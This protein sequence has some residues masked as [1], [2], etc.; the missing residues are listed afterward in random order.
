MAEVPER[1]GGVEA[2]EDLMTAPSPGKPV[3]FENRDGE[4]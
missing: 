4:H 3:H 2:P 1:F